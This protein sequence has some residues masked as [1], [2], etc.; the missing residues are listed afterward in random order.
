MATQIMT[1][2]ILKEKL[3]KK[4]KKEKL[5]FL[6]MKH[7]LTKIEFHNHETLSNEY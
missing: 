5:Y 4:I 7:S 3:T 6:T 2:E 1:Y